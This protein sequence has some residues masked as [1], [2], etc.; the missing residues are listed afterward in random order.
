MPKLTDMQIR[1]WIKAGDRFDG[2][3]DGNGLYICYPKN[4]TVPFWRFRY[5]LAG[6]QRAMV[7]GSYSELSLSKARETAKELSA[8][9]A[10]GY[11]VAAE[12]QERKAE[13][14]AKMEAE[15][16]AMRV[17]DLAAE[18]FER[19]ILPRW[20]HPDI[21]RRRID[22]D[23]NP[24]IGHM[25]VIDD[26]AGAPDALAMSEKYIYQI[27]SRMEALKNRSDQ[28]YKRVDSALSPRTK[29]EANNT[30]TM[31]E[32]I[33]DDLGGWD[34]LDPIE[35]RVFTAINPGPD[36]IL[37][38]ANLNRQRRLVGDALN[39]KQGPYKDADKEALSRLYGALAEDQKSVL[40]NTGYLRDFEVAQRLVAMRKNLE[41][42]M[43][44]LRGK[45]LNGDIAYKVTNSLQSMAKGD[46][47]GFRE[48]MQNTP[49]RTLRRELVGTA[50]RDMLSS[51]KRGADFNPSGFADWWQNLQHSGQLKT[52]AEHLPKETMSGLYDVYKVARAIKNA[53]AHEI[54]T[55]KLNEFV[56]RFNR[57]TAPY[58]LAAKHIQKIG[59]MVGAHFGSLG[60]IAGADIGARLASK[61][62][63][64]GGAGA[65][66]A[67][68][69]LIASPAFQSAVKNLHGKAPGHIVDSRIR[70]SP[71]WKS[72]FNSLPEQE[73][74]TIARLGIITWLSNDPDND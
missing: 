17:S 59:T 56:N 11:D 62:R 57:V 6:K 44:N 13:A 26:V 20:K 46:A 22:K 65:A 1:A 40:S 10:L 58:E 37:T 24:C 27:N 71:Q 33:A 29:V 38:Y 63:L 5:K 49:S 74:R 69:K 66:D 16:N 70:R 43:V 34:N 55:G 41:R 36:S 35:K 21:L 25:K 39:K 12:K 61:A 31:L 23:I 14:L 68:D 2:K 51:G 8:R 52:L 48:I 47:R 72:F 32:K 67:A 53:K 50:L 42:Q 4:Y 18:Y 64:A 3:A 15:K 28:L 45:T 19:Q 73:K 9:V 7:I 30:S 60:A 54:S